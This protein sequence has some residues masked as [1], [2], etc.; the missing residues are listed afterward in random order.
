MSR[1]LLEDVSFNVFRF[2]IVGQVS[3]RV[4]TVRHENIILS[5]YFHLLEK[6]EASRY[7]QRKRKRERIRKKK[8]TFSQTHHH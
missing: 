2:V 8:E 5:T 1:R 3:L 7:T 4:R 6:L